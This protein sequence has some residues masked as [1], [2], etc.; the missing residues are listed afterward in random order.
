MRKHGTVSKWNDERGFGIISL[1]SGPEEVFVH[2]SSFPRDGQRPRLGEMLSFETETGTDGKQKAILVQRPSKPSQRS[3]RQV[4]ER[5][6]WPRWIG[7]AASFA[8]LAFAASVLYGRLAPAPLSASS[9]TTAASE[10]R[11]LLSQPRFSCD[12]RTQCSQMTSCAEAEYFLSNCPAVQMDGN[13]DGEPCE[14][15]WCN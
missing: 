6:S 8:F 3:G 15:Q 4:K 5:S 1:G 7:T 13:G 12:G 2:I 10:A 9:L 11:P 14:Q